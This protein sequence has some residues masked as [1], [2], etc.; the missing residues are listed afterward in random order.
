[1][2]LW[3]PWRLHGTDSR[4]GE[5]GVKQGHALLSVAGGCSSHSRPARPALLS[6]LPLPDWR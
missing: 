2:L 1:M 5:P 3:L 4:C 6:P